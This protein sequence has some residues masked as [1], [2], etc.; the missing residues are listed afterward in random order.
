MR[1]LLL[2]ISFFIA[3]SFFVFSRHVPFSHAHI[4]E[5][6]VLKGHSRGKYVASSHRY[7]HELGIRY[8]SLDRPAE[9]L[10]PLQGPTLLRKKRNW[11]YSRLIWPLRN[12][13]ILGFV[14]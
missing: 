8:S 14:L 6:R 12:L 2:D 7:M 5:E 3:V 1:F 9:Q 11:S 10:R 4:L 13:D